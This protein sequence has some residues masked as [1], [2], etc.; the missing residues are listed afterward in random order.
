MRPWPKEDVGPRG[1]GRGGRGE[2]SIGSECSRWA[3]GSPLLVLCMGLRND[4]AWAGCSFGAQ[5]GSWVVVPLP[6]HPTLEGRRTITETG[7]C[8][9]DREHSVGLWPSPCVWSGGKGALPDSGSEMGP[10]ARLGP[11]LNSIP[12]QPG[13]HNVGSVVVVGGGKEKG[14]RGDI[15]G[16]SS[17]ED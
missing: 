15:G 17:R 13:R 14:H 5:E 3:E 8:S 9:L 16:L 11:S 10:L 2:H 7:K 4:Q 1:D 6:S 12:S